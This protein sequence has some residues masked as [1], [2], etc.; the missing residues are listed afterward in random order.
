M[1]RAPAVLRPI[2]LFE[3]LH[4]AIDPVGGLQQ[5]GQLG[6]A[7]ARHNPLEELLFEPPDPLLTQ[8]HRQRAALGD[9]VLDPLEGADIFA[10]SPMHQHLCLTLGPQAV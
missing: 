3:A 9:G 7:Q 1:Q 2:G 10:Q 4:N 8:R 6:L 5:F